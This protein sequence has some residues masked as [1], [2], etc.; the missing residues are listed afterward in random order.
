MQI[1]LRTVLLRWELRRAEVGPELT[2]RRN[3]TVRPGRGARVVLAERE[4][5]VAAPSSTATPA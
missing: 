4:P 1:V 3:I 5:A 2:S